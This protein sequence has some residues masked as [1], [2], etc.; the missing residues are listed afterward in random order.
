MDPNGLGKG[1]A[2]ALG[3]AGSASGGRSGAFWQGLPMLVA[4]D[5]VV[6]GRRVSARTF[7]TPLGNLTIIA[8]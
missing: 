5:V 4:K 2:K 6:V 8:A 7:P 3:A 1:S